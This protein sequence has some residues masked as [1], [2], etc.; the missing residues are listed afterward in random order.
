MSSTGNSCVILNLALWNW[1]W[2]VLQDRIPKNDGEEQFF[3]LLYY[4]LSPSS[5][6][7]NL[8]F[9]E[10]I[11][12]IWLHRMPEFDLSFLRLHFRGEYSE[13]SR[14]QKWFAHD[15]GTYSTGNPDFYSLESPRFLRLLGPSFIILYISGSTEPF[16]NPLKF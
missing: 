15:N 7:K 4:C 3:V 10:L 9:Q 12:E 1:A 6:V 2:M 13:S 8:L 16:P 14:L 5:T 11:P